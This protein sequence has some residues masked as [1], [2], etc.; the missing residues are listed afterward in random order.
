MT[1]AQLLAAGLAI[2]QKSRHARSACYP[3]VVT[4]NFFVTFIGV[5]LALLALGYEYYCCY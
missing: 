3:D 5:L 4:L 2:N 1:A